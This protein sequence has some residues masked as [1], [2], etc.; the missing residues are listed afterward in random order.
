MNI[1]DIQKVIENSL[2]KPMYS[3]Q[4]SRD[5]TWS[6]CVPL[7]ILLNRTAANSS[8]LVNT[9]CG[10]TTQKSSISFQVQGHFY[11]HYYFYPSPFYK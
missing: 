10:I 3:I 1:P 7:H 6:A 8:Y 5:R 2:L 9:A 4:S 11:F